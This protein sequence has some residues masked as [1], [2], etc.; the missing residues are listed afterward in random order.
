M[1][2]E[3]VAG[4]TRAHGTTPPAVVLAGKGAATEAD[5]PGPLVAALSLAD[6]VLL[7]SAASP[8]AT[9]RTE[10]YGRPLLTE[11]RLFVPTREGIAV[12]ATRGPDPGRLEAFL[13]RTAVREDLADVLGEE[14]RPTG[15]LIPWPGRGLLGVGGG[16]MSL[17]SEP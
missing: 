4:V 14:I 17:W 2:A 9:E 15:N 1:A 6:G 8:A 3:Q 10:T 12:F 7:W 13:D 5:P 11:E 16:T